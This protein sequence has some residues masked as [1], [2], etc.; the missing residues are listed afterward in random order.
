MNELKKEPATGRAVGVVMAL[1]LVFGS[2]CASNG[3]PRYDLIQTAVAVF[4][5]VAALVLAGVSGSRPSGHRWGLG[6]L[7]I[8]ALYAF[9]SAIIGGQAVGFDA[10]S[11][12]FLVAGA[13]LATA[14]AGERGRPPIVLGAA[15][16]ASLAAVAVLLG[17]FGIDVVPDIPFTTLELSAAIGP[18]DDPSILAS[19]AAMMVALGAAAFASGHTRGGGVLVLAGGVCLGGAGFPPLIVVVGLGSVVGFALGNARGGAAGAA[20]VVV[21]VAMLLAS[22]A[23]LEA[24]FDLDP[25][26]LDTGVDWSYSEDG[27][28]GSFTEAARGY[29]LAG[30]PFGHGSGAYAGEVERYVNASSSFATSYND[31]RPVSRHAPSAFL[32][33]AGDYGVTVPLALLTAVFLVLWRRSAAAIPAVVALGVLV[34]SP[35]TLSGPA[36]LALGVSLGLSFGP[37][38]PARWNA[39]PVVVVLAVVGFATVGH[40]VQTLQWGYLTASSVTFFENPA[41]SRDTAF[42]YAQRAAGTQRRYQSEMNHGNLRR[43]SDDVNHAEVRE[44][45][46]RA[47]DLRPASVDARMMLA[48]AYARESV[49]EDDSFERLG[50]VERMLG[51][52][53]EIDPNYVQVG[54]LRANAAAA[55][56]EYQPAIDGLEALSERAIPDNY[57]RRVLA[58]LG[59]I[60]EDADM[61]EEALSAYQRALPLATD[62]V[63]IG[64]YRQLIENATAWTESGE[65]PQVQFADPHLG[66]NHGD[67]PEEPQDEAAEV[68]AG[69]D[70]SGDG[71]DHDHDHD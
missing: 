5:V 53:A 39:Q 16:A 21:A 35:G 50:R 6:A 36:M 15:V 29:A 70:G 51:V 17:A 18:F 43:F 56:F 26:F 11:L 57:R 7:A 49:R 66:H 38:V 62:P 41:G 27:S 25:P 23:S 4:G 52:A 2:L 3:F 61:P 63:E 33:L 58:R 48:D 40:Q 31:G 60:Y 22:S 12:V 46:Q 13:A 20:G 9:A 59:E 34:Y 47:V 67:T 44:V 54:I 42:D 10:A 32:E 24:D 68:P 64:R 1:T 71:S 45:F 14:C 65:R 28:L 30:Q 8:A 37:E 69:G 55:G 19:W